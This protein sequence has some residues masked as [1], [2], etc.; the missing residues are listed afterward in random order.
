MNILCQ[1]LQTQNLNTIQATPSTIPSTTPLAITSDS[2]ECPK[3][4]TPVCV[5]ES[6]ATGEK[7]IQKF[8][9]KTKQTDLKGKVSY[10][11]FDTKIELMVSKTL[12]KN[13]ASEFTNQE[14]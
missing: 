5:A 10:N 14:K 4:Q 9:S 3:V 11:P 8:N 1:S 7:T 2:P 6:K 12:I 13:R